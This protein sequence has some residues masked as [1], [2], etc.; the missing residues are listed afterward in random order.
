MYRLAMGAALLM[1][2]LATGCASTPAPLVVRAADM[3]NARSLAP[4]QPLGIGLQP[5]DEIHRDV[6]IEGALVQSQKPE[7]PI[8]LKVVRR[9]FMRIDEDG[10]TT[11][12]DGK[13]FGDHVAPGSFRFGMGATKEKGVIATFAIRTPTPREPGG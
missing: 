12:L 3:A 9:F 4:G 1:I 7:V 2:T 5:G 11:S 8:R 10:V 13:T 6:S